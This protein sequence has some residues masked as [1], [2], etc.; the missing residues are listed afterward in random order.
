MY[1]AGFTT[2]LLSLSSSG[3]T[4]LFYA[5]R[6]FREFTIVH[7]SPPLPHSAVLSNL[8]ACLFSSMTMSLRRRIF[9][10]HLVYTSNHVICDIRS[11]TKRHKVPTPYIFAHELHNNIVSVKYN[12]TYL[13]LLLKFLCRRAEQ[14]YYT[15]LYC[16]GTGSTT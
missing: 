12:I 11:I 14:F 8:T 16:I 5:N 3:Y 10:T 4:A 6:V 1:T 7:T 15:N 13:L 9:P 2:V